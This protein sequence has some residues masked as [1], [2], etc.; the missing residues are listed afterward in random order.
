MK[1]D[2]N[3]IDYDVTLN[4]S[5]F[6]LNKNYQYLL[7]CNNTNEAG[8][9]TNAFEITKEGKQSQ[10]SD[11]VLATI[12]LIPFALAVLLLLGS[13]GLSEQHTAI[14]IGMYMLMIPSFWFSLYLAGVT[15]TEYMGFSAMQEAIGLAISI[16]GWIF[17]FMISYFAIY[18][19]YIIFKAKAENKEDK[20]E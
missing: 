7:Y 3:L 12:I 14:K 1:F 19:I 16:T 20:L 4:E 2:S 6:E 10:Y 5:L 17:F 8:F 13:M 9:I 15:I 18:L 11:F